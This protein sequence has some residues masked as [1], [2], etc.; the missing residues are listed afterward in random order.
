MKSL[1]HVNGLQPGGDLLS[2]GITN[3]QDGVHQES[4]SDHLI[5]ESAADRQ[6]VVWVCGEDLSGGRIASGRQ[7]GPIVECNKCIIVAESK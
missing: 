7:S 6:E 5:S 1:V 3:G 2:F 4:R